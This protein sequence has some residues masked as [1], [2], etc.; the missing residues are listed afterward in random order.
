MH[1]WQKTAIAAAPSRALAFFRFE[2]LGAFAGSYHRAVSAGRALRAEIDVLDINAEEAETL[3]DRGNARNFAAQGMEYNAAMTSLKIACSVVRMGAPPLQ[4]VSDKPH[5][6][7]LCRHDCDRGHWS[8]GRILRDYTMLF[9][10]P[11]PKKPA[12]QPHASQSKP[13][14]GQYINQRT[15]SAC[16][17]S[18]AVATPAP[19]PRAVPGQPNRR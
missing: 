2:R 5:H 3:K 14:T 7:S 10:P 17:P 11:A 9:D 12:A 16:R 18:R 19:A 6:R 4:L 8:S 15:R 13:D 1:R